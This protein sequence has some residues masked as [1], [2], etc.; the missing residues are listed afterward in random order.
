MR[1]EYMKEFVLTLVSAGIAS[2]IIGLFFEDDKEI[3]KYIKVVL[4]LCLTASIVSSSVSLV[5]KIRNIEISS[6]SE[7]AD[8]GVFR[9]K[10]SEYVIEDARE[11]LCDKL[12]KVIIEKTGIKPE[13]INIQFVVEQKEDNFFVDIKSIEIILEKGFDKKAVEECVYTSLGV[14]PYISFT[15]EGNTENENQ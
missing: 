6:E 8:I 13:A 3:M 10:Y 9:Q 1:Y 15:K 4:A 12:E 14:Y 5:Y 2:G 7:I 11:K